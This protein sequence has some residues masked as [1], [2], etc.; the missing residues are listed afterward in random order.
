MNRYCFASILGI[1]IGILMMIPLYINISLWWLF[2]SVPVSTIIGI[3]VLLLKLHI[4]ELRS[5]R[6][7]K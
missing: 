6:D 3:F 5:F 1:S 2:L 7:Y 4:E